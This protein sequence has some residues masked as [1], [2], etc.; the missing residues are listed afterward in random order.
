MIEAD[1]ITGTVESNDGNTAAVHL[2]DGAV[3]L[4]CRG[5]ESKEEFRNIFPVGSSR[6]S[7]RLAINLSDREG[8]FDGIKA[9][10]P[11]AK[12]KYSVALFEDAEGRGLVGV[13]VT[14]GDSGIT[15]FCAPVCESPDG[16]DGRYFAV[17][18]GEQWEW[19]EL[20]QENFEYV[21]GEIAA[22]KN[23]E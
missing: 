7:R 4:F 1:T 9:A 2:S 12:L 13:G 18:C 16:S 11:T 6:E 15:V 8:L 20:S 14:V 21:C 23:L 3:K 22:A 5:P 19:L 17:G 10:F